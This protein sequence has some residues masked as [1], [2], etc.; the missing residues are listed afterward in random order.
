MFTICDIIDGNFDLGKTIMTNHADMQAFGALPLPVS[1][2]LLHTSS[3]RMHSPH[4][5]VT[6][7]WYLLK[8]G[9][10]VLKVLSSTS[11]GKA[12]ASAPTE[13][14]SSDSLLLCIV[15]CCPTASVDTRTSL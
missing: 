4:A 8:N 6:V 7:P 3:S 10:S 11:E 12:A 13:C 9:S 1:K 2:M 14:F 15:R 5:S